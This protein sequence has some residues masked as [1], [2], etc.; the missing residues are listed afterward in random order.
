VAEITFVKGEA[1]ALDRTGVSMPDG[2]D[3]GTIALAVSGT[4]NL[5]AAWA[6]LPVGGMRLE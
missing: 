6:R 1:S 2:L 4:R 5:A 3:D